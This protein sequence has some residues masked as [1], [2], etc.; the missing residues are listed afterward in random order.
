MLKCFGI[1]KHFWWHK[2]S[3]LCLNFGP[4]S[5]FPL[6][7]LNFYS[8]LSL[9][10]KL[11]P[12]FST[13]KQNVRK[14]AEFKFYSHFIAF[15][16]S[17]IEHSKKCVEK[18]LHW[19]INLLFAL[20]TSRLQNSLWKIFECKEEATE[21]RFKNLVQNYDN[22][23]AIINLNGAW[24]CNGNY[25]RL[26]YRVKLDWQYTK[27]WIHSFSAIARPYQYNSLYRFQELSLWP[28]L[29]LSCTMLTIFIT[30]VIVNE[31]IEWRVWEIQL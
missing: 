22:A 5:S 29:K 3:Y 18:V 4:N 11:F 16:D 6:P 8:N 30:S 14:N 26:L 15:T 12:I 31:L 27:L 28:S 7:C 19:K 20:L 21:V 9:V 1:S 17:N 24:D 23:G 13:T 25:D 2:H 10:S